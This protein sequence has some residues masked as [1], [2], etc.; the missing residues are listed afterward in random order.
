M[1][2]HAI[3]AE[4]VPSIGRKQ[5]RYF[6]DVIGAGNESN[7]AGDEQVGVGGVIIVAAAVVF[8][9]DPVAGDFV[10]VLTDVR[11]ALG[12]LAAGVGAEGVE[13][14]LCGHSCLLI[15]TQNIGE[16]VEGL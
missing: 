9:V 15:R 3:E 1:I 13:I 4:P 5:G 2:F 16:G 8:A 6:H 14:V 10:L 12:I 7:D 11:I